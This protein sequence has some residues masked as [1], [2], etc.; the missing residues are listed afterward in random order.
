[1]C[2]PTCDG[3]L[4]PADVYQAFK[5]GAASGIEFIIGIPKNVAQVFRSFVGNQNSIDAVFSA[6]ADL[7]NCM[8]D[9][10]AHAVQAYIETQTAASTELEAKSKFVGQWLALCLYRTAV[11]LSEGGNQVHLMY[12]DEKPL[13]ENLG[14]GTVDVVATL[15]RNGEAL[16][17]YGSVMNKDL[18]ETLQTLLRKYVTGEALGLYRNEIGGLDAFEWK[19]FPQAL[20]VSDGKLLCDTIEERITEI[21][22]LLDFVIS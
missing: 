2:A 19:A 21:D 9:S 5:D 6:V 4:I 16:Q 1:M 17:M 20:I 22:G 12:W 7:R 11:R 14:S 18:S 13:I 8:D 10:T 15:L 3:A